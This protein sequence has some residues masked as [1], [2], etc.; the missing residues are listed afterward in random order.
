LRTE[1]ARSLESPPRLQPRRDRARQKLINSW[2]NCSSLQ[3][4]LGKLLARLQNDFGGAMASD[5][6]VRT[7]APPAA[8]ETHSNSFETAP[9]P[10]KAVATVRRKAD[11][12]RLLA[13]GTDPN[14]PR[15]PG[16]EILGELGRGG[17]GVV[18]KAKQT[19]LKRIVALKLIRGGTD[20]SPDQ[21]DRFRIEAEAVARL[22]HPN[23]VQIY[24]VGEH[25]GR[26]FCSLEYVAG[27][28]LSAKLNRG[29]LSAADSAE[30]LELLARAAHHAHQR[31]IVHRDLK[32]ANVLITPE[33]TPKVTDFGLAKR[34]EDDASGQT[35]T[36]AVMGTPSYMAPEQAAGKVRE[37]GPATDIWALG[38]IL[39]QCLTGCLPFPGDSAF[40]VIHA[41]VH[42]EVVAPSRLVP[43][44]PRDLETI[45]LKCLQK[46]P[47]SRYSSALTLAQD[48]ERFR[49][50]EPILARRQSVFGRTWRKLRKRAVVVGLALALLTALGVTAWLGVRF[51]SKHATETLTRE[52]DD[53]RLDASDL[54]PEERDRLEVALT[55]LEGLDRERAEVARK[56]LIERVGKRFHD[57]LYPR[58]EAADK[59][60]L[61]RDLL[62]IADR[63]AELASKLRTEY[64]GRLRSWQPVFDLVAPFDRAARFL[65]P[66]AVAVR[67]TGLV[68]TTSEPT[69]RVLT[70]SRGAVRAEVVFAPGWERASAL[71]V[72]IHL[73]AAPERPGQLPGY[74]LRLSPHQPVRTEGG[75]G[76]A[77]PATFEGAPGPVRAELLRNGV[78]LRQQVTPRATGALKLT[79]ERMGDQLRFCIND[80]PV[81]EF[82]DPIPLSGTGTSTLGLIWSG[83]GAVTRVRVE[84][85]D[86]PAV[87][88][89][90]ERGDDLY[91]HGLFTD[92]ARA[93]LE[94]A[95]SSTNPAVVAESR[96]K[97]AMSLL[98]ANRTREAVP[99]FEAV[100]GQSGDRWPVV[101]ACQLWLLH[102]T[103]NRFDEADTVAALITGRFNRD[104]SA[105]FVS[106]D[107]RERIL[108]GYPIAPINY[109]IP[110]PEHA[111]RLEAV[112]RLARFLT[113]ESAQVA[114]VYGLLIAQALAGQTERAIDTGL[115]LVPQAM[116]LSAANPY[117]VESFSWALRWYCWV[118]RRA[119]RGAEAMRSLDRW[120]ADYPSSVPGSPTWFKQAYLPIHLERARLLADQRKWAD[121]E[122]AIDTYL[123]E[124]PRPILN[125]H[126]YAQAHLMKGF[127]RWEQ[128]DPAG[129][130]RVWREGRFQVFKSQWPATNTRERPTGDIA[131]GKY[132]LLDQWILASLTNEMSDDE[133]KHLWA[134]LTG[135]FTHDQAIAGAC[136]AVQ[137]D[138]VVLRQAWRSRRGRELAERMAFTQ[139]S[140]TE[141]FRT[142][143]KLLAYEKFRQDLFSA[144]PFPE[145]DQVMWQCVCDL[146]NA[147]LGRRVHMNSAVTLVMAWQG[148]TGKLGWA[149]ASHALPA[150]ARGGISYLMGLKYLKLNKPAEAKGMLQTALR[151]APADSP[152]KKLVQ[153]ELDRL[154]AER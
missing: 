47:G 9:L 139:L 61:E 92:A 151:D 121:A 145:Q 20:A 134:A 27:G 79:A 5:A 118:L 152:L 84:N 3:S 38:A 6:P 103:E 39:Y 102:L 106:L 153:E 133:G 78:V 34:L 138:P 132:G 144:A 148:V 2:L 113:D 135:Y 60:R 70:A 91:E 8:S 68:R 58:V 99:L 7:V 15:I 71:G 24:E 74:T 11:D 129:S 136:A 128:G 1:L 56:K 86:V 111:R 62:W 122:D 131:P 13:I 85:Q 89:L 17:M 100:A 88:S 64:S 51:Q 45:C 143:V 49:A 116:A 123:K 95:R 4:R 69:V 114:Q 31:G 150:D 42:A 22:Q 154:N 48:V 83:P 124:S 141:F 52:F 119:G 107:L 25:H 59:P 23:I 109:L 137:M 46:L 94:Q 35:R 146:S 40:A 41:V 10:P 98:G 126:L 53:E 125:Y 82:A 142:P 72:V 80:A 30:L 96:C 104:Q 36:G 112:T 43:R 63:D 44:I 55:R 65:P 87:A 130:L 97:A 76:P 18:Y 101:A 77:P 108:S 12:K 14:V 66:S 147:F 50:G 75:Q 37:I 29:P 127:C 90:L 26:P 93:Y 140:P 149:S 67:P 115:A 117:S 19:R 16:Y 33:G 105:R 120:L 32:P 110:D 54:S 28:S 73:P 81:L 57:S 21:L